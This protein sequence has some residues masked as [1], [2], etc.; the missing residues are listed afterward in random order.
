MSDRS[1][2]AIK[3]DLADLDEHYLETLISHSVQQLADLD[4]D[5]VSDAPTAAELIDREIAEDFLNLARLGLWVVQREQ[6]SR[7]N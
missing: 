7:R 1:F 4:T 6:Q 3:S 2:Q 5:R